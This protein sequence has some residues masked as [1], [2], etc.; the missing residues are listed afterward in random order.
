MR[1][2]R[3][4]HRQAVEHRVRVPAIVEHVYPRCAVWSPHPWDVAAGVV[5]GHPRVPASDVARS[6]AEYSLH[7]RA[8]LPVAAVGALSPRERVETPSPHR[9]GG[10]SRPGE[11]PEACGALAASVC[12]WPRKPPEAC[13]GAAMDQAS[14]PCAVRHAVRSGRG[15]W[16]LVLATWRRPYGR[17]R[18]ARTTTKKP[19]VNAPTTP[20]VNASRRA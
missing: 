17:K 9:V 20:S 12:R 15:L 10:P 5:G 14:R 3:G 18:F 16:V 8:P 19:I 7:A 1:I 13:H 4:A 11:P 2:P 6:A